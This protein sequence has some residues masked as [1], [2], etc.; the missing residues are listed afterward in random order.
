MFTHAPHILSCWHAFVL[1]CDRHII[2]NCNCQ[3]L[4]NC[5]CE[6]CTQSCSR[7]CRPFSKRDWWTMEG[8]ESSKPVWSKRSISCLHS[9]TCDPTTS[10]HIDLPLPPTITGLHHP[11]SLIPKVTL[12]PPLP[13]LLASIYLLAKQ[14]CNWLSNNKQDELPFNN[15]E[16]YSA[17]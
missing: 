3:R 13:V 5:S 17:V 8:S 11:K 16:R 6:L 9:L 10:S 15:H 2:C 7:V 12:P 14:H 1:V 4:W